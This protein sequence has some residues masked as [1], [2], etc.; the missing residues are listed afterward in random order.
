MTIILSLRQ[1]Q[2]QNMQYGIV[3]GIGIYYYSI[4]SFKYQQA[5]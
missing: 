5:Y 3:L 2:Y 1:V 4:H